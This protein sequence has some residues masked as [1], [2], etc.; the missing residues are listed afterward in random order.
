MGEHSISVRYGCGIEGEQTPPEVVGLNPN[1]DFRSFLK[2][3]LYYVPQ[4]GASLFAKS[5]NKK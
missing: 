4:G 2:S 5:F 1:G 3:V